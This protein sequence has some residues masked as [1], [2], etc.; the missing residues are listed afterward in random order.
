MGAVC[1]ACC[2]CVFRV[3]ANPGYQGMAKY[4]RVIKVG[5]STGEMGGEE[6]TISIV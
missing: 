4:A 2:D 6:V 3:T 5:D 1:S